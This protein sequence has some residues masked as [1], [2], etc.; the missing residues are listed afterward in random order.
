MKYR[1]VEKKYGQK[2]LYQVQEQEPESKQWM[3]LLN[4]EDEVLEFTE[5]DDAKEFVDYLREINETLDHLDKV[6][7]EA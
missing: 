1:V 4:D 7:Y 5:L 3:E 6:V 2:V